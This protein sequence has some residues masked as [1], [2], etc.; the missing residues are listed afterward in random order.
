ME[1]TANE[2][3][4]PIIIATSDAMVLGLIQHRELYRGKLI[5]HPSITNGLAG[6]IVDKQSFSGLCQQTGVP[7]PQTAFPATVDEILGL[8]EEFQFP[9][10]LKPI[11]G[12]LW[13]ERLN[14][15]KVLVAQSRDDLQQMIDKF[16]DQADGLMVQELIPGAEK[17]IRV[18][19]VYRGKDGQRV[20]CFVG[21]KVR[22]YPPNFGTASYAK[23][24]YIPEIEALSWKFVEGVD[25]R[26]ICGTEFKFDQRDG[27]FKMIEVNPRPT[28]WFQ[29]VT[30][31]GVD[32]IY[33]AY[34][35]LA[36]ELIPPLA[37]QTDGVTWCF[38]DKDFLT[39]A[40]HL[41]HFDISP[42]SLLSTFSP[43]NHGAV[44]NWRDPF[45]FLN[46]PFYYGRRIV[47]KLLGRKQRQSQ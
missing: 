10:L 35:D 38:Q 36:G 6:Q 19:A 9:L 34:R 32:L 5:V 30:S 21:Q 7:T 26:G 25:Y 4:P 44:L 42:L 1:A 24:E 20:S 15:R 22:Q 39:W 27:Q 40:H 41:R 33:A 43:R 18:G 3:T 12:H 8:A 11:L 17:N 28:L 37:K 16:G 31:A 46:S 45:P 47:D 23:S 13:R 14:G 2:P 29:L